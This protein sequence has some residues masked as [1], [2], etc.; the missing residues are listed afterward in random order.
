MV[1]L[2]DGIPFSHRREETGAGDHTHG[3]RGHDA[4]QHK[5]VTE[6]QR[7]P[8]STGLSGHQGAGE[9]AGGQCLMVTECQAG[10]MRRFWRRTVVAA[11]RQCERA[12]HQ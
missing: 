6:G 3:P 1:C 8:D 5:P 9:G 2:H 10:V 12:S 7:S 4:E 11:E